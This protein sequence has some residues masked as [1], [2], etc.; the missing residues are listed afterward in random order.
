MLS[1]YTKAGGIGGVLA[2]MA[3][4]FDATVSAREASPGRDHFPMHIVSVL[5]HEE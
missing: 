4:K 1:S 5:T 3:S 2:P